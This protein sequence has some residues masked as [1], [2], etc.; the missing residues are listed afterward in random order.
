M[1]P[2]VRVLFAAAVAAGLAGLSACGTKDGG[3]GTGGAGGGARPKIAVVTNCTDPFWDLCEAGA[4]KAARDFDVDLLFRQ[5][6]RGSAEVQKPIIDAWVNQGVSGIAVSVID[7]KGQTED[8]ALVAKKVPLVTM[9][10]DAPDSGRLCYVGV[11]NR[12]AGRAVGR[13]VKK[14]RPNGGTVALF[15]GSTTSAN[16]IA[17]P[18]GVLEELATPDA[19]GKPGTH[20]QRP[21]LSGKW[22]GKYFLVDGEPKTDD[23]QKEKAIANARDVLN[24]VEGVPDLCFVGL[25][26]YNPPAILEAVRA[27]GQAG[28]VK[29]VGFD[30][31]GE[32]LK[33]I[34]AGEIEG[35]VVQDPFN[36]G[37]KSV[38]VLAAAARGD[39]SKLVT[40]S[41]A[42]QVIT[43]DGGPDQD[44]NGLHSAPSR[45][46]LVC[47]ATIESCHDHSDTTRV[48]SGA[49]SAR[50]NSVS[51][52]LPG[53]SCASDVPGNIHAWT[54]PWCGAPSVISVRT[55]AAPCRRK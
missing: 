18:A 52:A 12:E 11:D 30:E 32:T 16:G 31:D 37:Y 27:R 41:S 36:Y 34:A 24:R 40:G 8:L 54:L 23:M 48:P 1:S 13:L 42:Y 22:Y 51:H 3:H 26:A 50:F 19:N 29:I 35:T 46:A 39:K 14:C 49:A 21:E 43:T 55:L 2:S 25:Y 44:I 53:R 17:R 45:R 33:S 7:P 47:G 20:P 9:D 4:K 28:K 15:I 38:E 10:N 6:E 5:P